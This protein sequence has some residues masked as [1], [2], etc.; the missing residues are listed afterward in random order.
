MK[1]DFEDIHNEPIENYYAGIKSEAYR[2]RITR[3]LRGYLMDTLSDIIEGKTFEEKANNLVLKAKKD[4]D[5]AMRIMLNISKNL[6]RRTELDH[7]DSYYLN[8]SS[9]KNDFKPFKK[10]FEMNNVSLGWKKIYSTFLE[11]NLH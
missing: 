6:R 7:A 10:L 8:P 4:N 1:E 3:T 5:F 11:W 9:I 2:E